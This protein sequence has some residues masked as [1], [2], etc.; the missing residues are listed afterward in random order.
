VSLADVV[1]HSGVSEH[2]WGKWAPR[3]DPCR[4]DKSIVVVSEKGY[5]TA[6]E[7]CQFQWVAEPPGRSAD[8]LGSHALLKQ[9]RPH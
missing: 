5:L 3:A 4:D 7:S 8:L 1:R 2:F 6:Q 9:K